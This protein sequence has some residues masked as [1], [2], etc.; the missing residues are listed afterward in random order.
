MT[1][2]YYS[3]KEEQLNLLDEVISY[4]K[5]EQGDAEGGVETYMIN[6]LMAVERYIKEN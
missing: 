5:A 3:V 6:N 1:D 4:L 2:G